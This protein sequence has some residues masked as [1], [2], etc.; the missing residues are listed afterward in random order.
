MKQ[1]ISLFDHQYYIEYTLKADKFTLLHYFYSK[2]KNDEV[3]QEVLKS[4][5]KQSFIDMTAISELFKDD[6]VKQ[7]DL[8]SMIREYF[9]CFQMEKTFKLEQSKLS[10]FRR[11]IATSKIA[12]QKELED[13]D[14]N[15]QLATI[16]TQVFEK[17]NIHFESIEPKEKMEYPIQNVL[18]IPKES[19]QE[20]KKTS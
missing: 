2:G 8:I 7:I 6:T 13:F 11:A 4:L 20:K 3:L 15:L 17:A 14:R 19:Y 16:N 12:T 9:S 10:Q 1:M 18:S 5:R